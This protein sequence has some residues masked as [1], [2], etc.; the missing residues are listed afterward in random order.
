MQAVEW[1]SNPE[2]DE[3]KPTISGGEL[4]ATENEFGEKLENVDQIPKSYK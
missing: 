3:A 4:T 2:N 1:L